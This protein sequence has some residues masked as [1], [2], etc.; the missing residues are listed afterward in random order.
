M[1]WV[2]I[3]RWY[4]AFKKERSVELIGGPGMPCR[5]THKVNKNTCA[6]LI[7]D[8]D[9]ITSN[10]LAD[11][12]QISSGSVN[13]ILKDIGFS[14]MCA[15]W[16]TWLLTADQCTK[17]VRIAPF[18]VERLEDARGHFGNDVTDKSWLYSYDL[19]LKQQS[20]HWR[21]RGTGPPLKQKTFCSVKRGWSIPILFH[22]TP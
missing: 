19:E 16:V 11:M 14:S 12:L 4:E 6:T 7:V 13:N 22:H 9:S 15:R 18:W 17:R 5:A 20:T 1:V 3:Y 2:T 21:K 10:E 8:G